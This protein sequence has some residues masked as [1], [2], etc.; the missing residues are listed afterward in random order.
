MFFVEGWES[1][2]MVDKDTAKALMFVGLIITGIGVAMPEHTTEQRSAE[3]MGSE[4]TATVEED[5]QYRAPTIVGGGI[6][7]T[8]GMFAYAGGKDHGGESE[9]KAEWDDP[10]LREEL[11]NLRDYLR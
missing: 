7:F 11:Q 4:V 8:I 9:Q 1:V 2:H 5:N 3:V 6:M 10:T